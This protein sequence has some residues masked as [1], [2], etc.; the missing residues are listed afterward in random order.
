MRE[1]RGRL[2]VADD[3][4]VNRL[5]LQRSLEAEKLRL[6]GGGAPRPPASPAKHPVPLPPPK[7][8]KTPR[9]AKK[10]NQM[11]AASA[12]SPAMGV[13]AEIGS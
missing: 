5:L 4:K 12:A 10:K 2:L 13:S 11:T 8:S 1:T 9:S 6:S 3:N 7:P